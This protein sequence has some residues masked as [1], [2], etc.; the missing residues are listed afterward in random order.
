MKAKTTDHDVRYEIERRR[1]SDKQPDDTLMLSGS[2][3]N[4][5]YEYIVQNKVLASFFVQ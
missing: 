3:E 4:K 5:E 1:S 2:E